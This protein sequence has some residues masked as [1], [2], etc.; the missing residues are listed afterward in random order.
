MNLMPKLPE[1]TPRVGGLFKIDVPVWVWACIVPFIIL[2][3]V[4]SSCSE[5]RIKAMELTFGKPPTL[6]TETPK[7]LPLTT[8]QVA[9]APK[10][11][12]PP[13]VEVPKVETRQP[14]PQPMPKVAEP[15]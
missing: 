8:P 7:G 11:A 5:C 6:G 4:F 10:K 3:L 2:Y 9:E 15:K 14:P 13:K 1:G 12:E